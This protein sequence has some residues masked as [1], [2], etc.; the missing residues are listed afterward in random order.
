MD[1]LFRLY[2]AERQLMQKSQISINLVVKEEEEEV[3]YSV[4]ENLYGCNK[5]KLDCIINPNEFG[6]DLEESINSRIASS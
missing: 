4:L 6:I 1:E 5:S 3:M 2:T